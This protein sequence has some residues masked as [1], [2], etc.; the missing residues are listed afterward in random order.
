MTIHSSLARPADPDQTT[1]TRP[2]S[3]WIRPARIGWILTLV[4]T[5]ALFVAGVPVIFSQ[6]DA[7]CFVAT[8]ARWQ[9][10]PGQVASLGQLGL[11]LRFYSIFYL[12][13]EALLVLAWCAIASLLVWRKSDDPMA[14]FAP[15]ALTAFGGGVFVDTLAALGATG[16]GWWWAVTIHKVAGSVALLGFFYL[17][18]N[19]SF[20]PGWTRWAALGWAGWVA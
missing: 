12:T 10:S 7:P 2:H 3:S 6:L 11:T 4:V 16:G 15:F 5:L 1:S 13:T 17:F 8:C 20:V 19:G 9:L 18:P 14:L